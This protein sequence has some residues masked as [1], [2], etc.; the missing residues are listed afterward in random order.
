MMDILHTDSTL[1]DVGRNSKVKLSASKIVGHS[2][3]LSGNIRYP[4]V[5]VDVVDAK[6]IEALYAHPQIC[7]LY[8]SDAADE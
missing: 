5:G 3:L 2:I 8:T 7:L 4:I 6:Q 1:L